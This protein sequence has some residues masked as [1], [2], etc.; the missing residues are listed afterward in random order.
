MGF[1]FCHAHFRQ[2][3]QNYLGLDLK[4]SGQIIDSNFHPLSIS[5]EYLLRDHNDL[6]VF[7][8]ESHYES[9]SSD[10]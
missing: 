5:S 4:L 1:L 2:D 10:S 6:T 9:S 7:C 8:L 3:I